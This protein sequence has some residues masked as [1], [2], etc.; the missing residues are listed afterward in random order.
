M[1]FMVHA[2]D[3]VTRKYELA[4]AQLEEARVGVEMK[5][6]EAEVK[7]AEA[8]LARQRAEAL[9]NS[10]KVERLKI[11]EDGLRAQR[12]FEAEIECLNRLFVEERSLREKEVIRARKA[13]K[14]ELSAEFAEKFKVT[15]V[16]T[17]SRA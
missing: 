4:K 16:V 6:A 13:A 11:A 14:R 3:S 5:A 17:R 10:E 7:I 12:K 15:D 2:Y 9:A 1:N 8:D